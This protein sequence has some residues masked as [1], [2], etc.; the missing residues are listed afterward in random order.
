MNKKDFFQNLQPNTLVLT[1]NRRLSVG[2][3][4]QF[5]Q[6]QIEKGLTVWPTLPILPYVSWMERL[7]TDFTLTSSGPFKR[8]LSEQEEIVLWEELIARTKETAHLMQLS[9]TADLAKSAWGLL[10]QY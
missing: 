9:E 4:Q 7:Y 5:Q 2:L 3:T 1:P 10:K 6:L 8:V